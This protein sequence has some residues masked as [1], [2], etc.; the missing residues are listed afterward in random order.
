MLVLLLML[1]EEYKIEQSSKRQSVASS[2]VKVGYSFPAQFSYNFAGATF[3]FD[4]GNKLSFSS[5]VDRYDESSSE[6]V[7]NSELVS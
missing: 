3:N 5:V 1:G 7:V 2:S 4:G 6:T